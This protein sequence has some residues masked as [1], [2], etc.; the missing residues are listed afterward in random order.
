MVID[1]DFSHVPCYPQL[2]AQIG[3][4]Q[5]WELPPLASESQ[6]V[7]QPN[8]VA[9]P[10]QQIK[11][12]SLEPSDNLLAV[13]I[14]ENGK[15]YSAVDISQASIEPRVL[16]L[17]K[18]NEKENNPTSLLKFGGVIN[19]DLKLSDVTVVIEDYFPAP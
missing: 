2:Q 11:L 12:L 19:K 18:Q 4:N 17:E 10:L 7:W 16:L 1:S 5:V 3:D 6:I 14:R 15:Q 13:D 9:V 8:T